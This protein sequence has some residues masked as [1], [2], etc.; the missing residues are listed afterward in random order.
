MG[1]CK[2][3]FYPQVSNCHFIIYKMSAILAPNLCLVDEILMK[4]KVGGT[5]MGTPMGEL[6][7]DPCE[8]GAHVAIIPLDVQTHSFSFAHYS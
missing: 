7:I 8:Y 4:L 6:H 3:D 2:E 1:P 5:V